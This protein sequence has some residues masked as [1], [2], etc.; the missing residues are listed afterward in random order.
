MQRDKSSFLNAGITLVNLHSSEKTPWLKDQICNFYF[1]YFVSRGRF[2]KSR[3]K[4]F[5][6]QKNSLILLVYLN[7][8]AI[9]GHEV[10][11]FNLIIS[12]FLL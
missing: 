3:L 7:L 12:S 4:K 8:F 9:I 11:T 5:N 1:N 6:A 2:K 10:I